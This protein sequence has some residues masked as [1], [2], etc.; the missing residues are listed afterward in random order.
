M[1]HRRRT[2][3]VVW[4]DSMAVIGEADI[5]IGADANPFERALERSTSAITRTVN[6]NLSKIASATPQELGKM[7]SSVGSSMQSA[8]KKLT[9]SLTVPIVGATAAAGTLVTALGFKRLVG[10][11]TARSQFKGLG[12]DA[13]AVMA[14]VDKGVTN[15]SLSMAQGASTAV[16]ILA[17]GAVPLEGLEDQIKRVANVSAAYN[18]DAEHASYLLN[19][20]LTKQKVTWGDLAQMQQNQIPIV[21]ALADEFGYTGEEIQK[22]AQK[23]EISIDMLNQ[24]LDAKAG[25]AAEEYAKSWSGISANI[26]ANL[27]KIGAKLME[28]SFEI[29]KEKAADFLKFLQSPEFANWADE[30]GEK[31]GNMVAKVVDAISKLI[32]RWNNLSPA[33]QK[34]IGAFV[35]LAAAAGPMI[36]ITGKLVSGFGG[37]I[38]RFPALGTFI[39][40]IAGG[41]TKAAG[42]S[43]TF[44]GRIGLAGSSITRFLGPIGLA[45]ASLVAMYTSSESFREAIDKLVGIIGGVLM[46]VFKSLVGVLKALSPLFELIMGLVGKLAGILGDALGKALEALMPV[47]QWLANLLGKVLSKAVEALGAAIEWLVGLFSRANDG[48]SSFGKAWEWV[49][50]VMKPIA[51]WFQ[52]TFGPIIQSL[53]EMFGAIWEKLKNFWE[54]VGVPTL[55]AIKLGWEMLWQGIQQIWEA[56]GPPLMLA[57]ETA[58]NNIQIV[59]ETVW[60]IIVVIFQTA[61]DTIQIII[62]TAL[63]VIQ[64]IID[65]VTAV[66]Q[67]DWEGFWD[68]IL[69]IVET[70]WEGIT[71]AVETAVNAVKEIID[72][73]LQGISAIWENI[74]N[75]IKEVVTQVWNEIVSA[76]SRFIESVRRTVSN[77]LSSIQGT[78]NSV[79][80]SISTFFSEIWKGIQGAATEFMNGVKETFKSVLEFIGSIPE[81][82]KD[83]FSDMGTLLLD[84]G[85]ALVNGF[86]EGI[87]KAWGK[88]TDWVSKGLSK[89]RNLFPFSPA[90]TGPFSGRGWVTY[91]GESLGSAFGSS[92]V[93]ALDRSE[94]DISGSLS[95]IADDFTNLSTPMFDAFD[96][97]KSMADQLAAGL[98]GGRNSVADAAHALAS[99]AQGEFSGTYGPSIAGTGIVSAA[100]R[101]GTPGGAAAASVGSSNNGVVF[102]A[103]LIAVENMTVDSDDRVRELAQELWARAQRS[104][105]AQ[106]RI[107]LGGVVR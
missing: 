59:F 84:S 18:V 7:V 26:I 78:W 94:K 36:G 6:K 58:W 95:S 47:I 2:G 74:W 55:D 89:L 72:S 76:V 52:G 42:S 43:F 22:M 4:G 34:T 25:A 63:G 66:I 92:I 41:F 96:V 44:A 31:I 49:L 70:I 61:W 75:S 16:G 20:V 56:I 90:K 57:I 102:N 69:G 17:T 67:G 1:R 5:I 73:I 79:W 12:Y 101:L 98:D 8:G 60:N 85:K 105:R 87:K 15:T 28:P 33:M 71:T 88:L 81:K 91:S 100:S 97:G 21:T 29:I 35:G 64:G 80:T 3:L 62:E 30:W 38:T 86:L 19:N 104:D 32:S 11:D 24:A 53:G 40:Q 37:L 51:A 23:G 9:N 65:T 106:G 50:G 99:A 103:P 77:V 45:V 48:T 54:T 68:A 83:L 10:I 39:S 14:Q 93:R 46:S 82:I 107:N 27:G 13:E